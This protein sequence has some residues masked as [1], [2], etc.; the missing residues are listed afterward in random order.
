VQ[1]KVSRRYW[2]K[3]I[4]EVAVESMIIGNNSEEIGGV[5]QKLI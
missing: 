2:R 5:K 4:L 1:D 3:K